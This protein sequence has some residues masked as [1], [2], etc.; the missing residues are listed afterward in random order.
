M[1]KSTK[2][3]FNTGLDKTPVPPTPVMERV[4]APLVVLIRLARSWEMLPLSIL[5]DHKLLIPL[6]VV[7]AACI[8][9][10]VPARPTLPPLKTNQAGSLYPPLALLTPG[11]QFLLL[12][13]RAGF[14]VECLLH[15]LDLVLTT[16]ATCHSTLPPRPALVTTPAVWQARLSIQLAAWHRCPSS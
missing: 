10:N 1:I 2:N 8:L 16:P 6:L 14:Q 12:Q 4:L 7:R 15:N 11:S 9:V 5:V 3:V 13:A